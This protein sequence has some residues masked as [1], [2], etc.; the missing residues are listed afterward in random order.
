MVLYILFL[1]HIAHINGSKNTHQKKYKSM[2]HKNNSRNDNSLSKDQKIQNKLT[3]MKFY[4][5][6]YDQYYYHYGNKIY[7]YY[8]QYIDN[9]TNINFS[10][11]NIYGIL[12]ILQD[13]YMKCPHNIYKKISNIPMLT[14]RK[15]HRYGYL[16]TLIITIHSI[17][18]QINEENYT[19]AKI[20]ELLN[21]H[22]KNSIINK[23]YNLDDYSITITEDAYNQVIE[24][25]LILL[26]LL[27]ITNSSNLSLK[28]DEE[29]HNTILA[30][31]T[32]IINT[33]FMKITPYETCN[34]FVSNKLQ[35][36]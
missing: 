3:D 4:P 13:I 9:K 6:N 35:K 7:L 26:K 34:A 17:A 29:Y 20:N 12:N 8:Q 16:D 31:N 1:I 11:S 15:V 28:D 14:T 5:L 25:T 21:D 22:A 2:G 27:A 24:D 18:L 30:Y 19:Y 36:E 23:T 33:E 32:E 10:S